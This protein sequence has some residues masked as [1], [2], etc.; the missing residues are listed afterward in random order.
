MDKLDVVRGVEGVKSRV[1]ERGAFAVADA[2]GR[3]I[4]LSPRSHGI[5]FVFKGASA[6]LPDDFI[7]LLDGPDV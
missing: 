7:T 5:W 2:T 3:A 4:T 1:R 6:S